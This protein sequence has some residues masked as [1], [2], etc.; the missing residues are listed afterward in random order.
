MPACRKELVIQDVDYSQP[1]ESVLQADVQGNIHDI[2]MGISFNVSALHALEKPEESISDT[3]FRL[4]RDKAG[5]YYLTSAGYS[6]VYIFK[7]GSEKLIMVNKVEIPESR[8]TEPAFNARFPLIQLVDL[9][10]EKV[11]HINHKG[12]AEGETS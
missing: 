7:S 4:I 10:S 11:Y 8:L 6:H 9:T 3:E 1:V 12:L 2:R 5:Y